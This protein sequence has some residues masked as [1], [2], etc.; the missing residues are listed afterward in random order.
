MPI[1]SFKTVAQ[2]VLIVAYLLTCHFAVTQNQPALQLLALLFLGVGILLRGLFENSFF[3]WA[4]LAAVAVIVLTT[5]IFGLSKYALYLPPVLLPLFMW[6]LFFRSLMP[7]RTP[8]VSAVA[9]EVRGELSTELYRYT[10]G[11]TVLWCLLFAALA[12][13]SAMLPLLGSAELWSLFTNFLNYL[14]IAILFVAEFA[15]RQRRFS[16]LEHKTF[17]QYL[18]RITQVNMREY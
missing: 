3:T 4:M 18:Q 1:A 11:V 7:A 17:W 8:L 15:F 13:G 5:Y 12:V 2:I 9:Q 6:S 14:I 10:R 16:D